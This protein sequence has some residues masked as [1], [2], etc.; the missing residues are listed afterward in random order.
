MVES[1]KIGNSFSLFLL[2]T[3]AP[4]TFFPSPYPITLN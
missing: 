1:Q 2:F 3:F 4:F